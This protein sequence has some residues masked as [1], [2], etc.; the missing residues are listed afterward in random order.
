[1]FLLVA[2]SC[3][4]YQWLTESDRRVSFYDGTAICDSGLATGWYRFGSPAGTQMATSCPDGYGTK[5]RCKTHAG[6]WL[7]GAHPTTSEGEV[8][9]TVCF[10]WSSSC[11]YWSMNIKVLNCGSYYI[12]YLAKPSAGCSLRYCGNY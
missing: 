6:G 4:S 7:N 9:R 2:N 5:Y 11:C 8:T 1:M 12:Y 3:P 10:A